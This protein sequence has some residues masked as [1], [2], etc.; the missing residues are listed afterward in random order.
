MFAHH[1]GV[2][3]DGVVCDTLVAAEGG[4]GERDG[5]WATAW[6]EG[7]D[8]CDEYYLVFYPPTGLEEARAVVESLTGSS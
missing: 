6:F 1:L 4:P 2:V 3:S 5:V 8:R 7:P